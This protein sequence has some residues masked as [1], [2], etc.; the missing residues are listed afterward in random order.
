M[1]NKI[2]ADE[3]AHLASLSGLELTESEMAE[4]E[5][6]ISQIVDSFDRLKALDT[7]GV[8]PTFQVNDL[9][10][11]WRDDVIEDSSVSREQLLALA[12]EQQDNSVKVPKVL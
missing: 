8:E 10:N 6:E 5:P 3:I 7:S 12:P 2:S 9:V 11:V 4:F 1:K